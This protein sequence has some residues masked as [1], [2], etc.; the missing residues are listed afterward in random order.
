M[1][2]CAGG[3]ARGQEGRIER[4]PDLEAA[5]IDNRH[6]RDPET[7][8]KAHVR[9]WEALRRAGV[10]ERTMNWGIACPTGPHRP[11]AGLRRAGQGACWRR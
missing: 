1:P 11:G 5:R 3:P 4:R 6:R 9:R 10:V 7:F 8:V 2:R